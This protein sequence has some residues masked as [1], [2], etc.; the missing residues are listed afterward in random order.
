[1]AKTVVDQPRATGGGAQP[2]REVAPLTDRAQALMEKDQTGTGGRTGDQVVME[3]VVGFEFE[4]G[5]GALL[6]GGGRKG[7]GAIPGR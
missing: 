3:A 7:R 4:Q 6:G 1:V 5:H 2:L